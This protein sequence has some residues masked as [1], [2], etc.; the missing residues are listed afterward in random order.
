[1]LAGVVAGGRPWITHVRTVRPR[2]D[3]FSFYELPGGE[4]ERA[5][6]SLRR[7]DPRLGYLGD[8]HSHPADVGPSPTDRESMRTIGRSG[9]LPRPLLVV[10]RRSETIYTLDARQWTGRALRPL[11]VVAAG[12]LPPLNPRRRSLRRI[13]EWSKGDNVIR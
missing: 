5:V 7:L 1:V 13:G 2:R 11:R 10:V 12:D 3:M 9:D 4:R 6:R 8:W